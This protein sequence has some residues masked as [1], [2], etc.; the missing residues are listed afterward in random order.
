VS[1]AHALEPF[2]PVNATDYPVLARFRNDTGK[3]MSL[4]LEMVPEQVVLSPG[5]EI[6]L[7]ARPSPD[8]L[9]ISVHAVDGGLQVFANTE[10][11]PDW[12]VRF[13]GKVLRACNPLRLADH[14]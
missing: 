13:R 7:L 10:F 1:H 5:H 4:N 12:H 3:E 2:I 6:E 8:L 9:P 14:E 11:D